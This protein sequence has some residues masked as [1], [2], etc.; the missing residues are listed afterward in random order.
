MINDVKTY[1]FVRRMYAMC[2]LLCEKDVRFGCSEGVNVVRL[3]R[4][5]LQKDNI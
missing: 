3:Q 4:V 2:M 1:I 5:T